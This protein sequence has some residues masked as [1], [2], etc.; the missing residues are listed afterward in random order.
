MMNRERRINRQT[1]R[2][3]DGLT[4]S[5]TD[6]TSNR[7]TGRE[8]EEKDKQTRRQMGKI[9]KHRHTDRLNKKD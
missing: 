1:D 5:H 8:I 6:S 7:H 2:H 9:D 3:A 4:N